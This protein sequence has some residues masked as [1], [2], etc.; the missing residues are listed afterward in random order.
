MKITKNLQD[1]ANSNVD[2]SGATVRFHMRPKNS[3][4]NKVDAAA[5]IVTAAQ[6]LVEY[7][8]AAADLDTAG[9]FFGEFEVTFADSTVQKFPNPGHLHI[10]V[11]E[12]LD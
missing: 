8:F 9:D 2:V 6:G 7:A 12:D 5:T 4:T 1:Y 10:Q 11:T 3:L